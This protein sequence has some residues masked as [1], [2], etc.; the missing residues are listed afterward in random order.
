[1]VRVRPFFLLRMRVVFVDIPVS[2][3]HLISIIFW[4]LCLLGR[5]LLTVCLFRC[6]YW[7]NF[8]ATIPTTD[9]CC[10]LDYS[11]GQAQL[12]AVVLGKNIL[13]PKPSH[14][15]CG[16][17]CNIYIVGADSDSASQ[18]CPEKIREELGAILHVVG[19]MPRWP[20]ITYV[21]I[22]FHDIFKLDI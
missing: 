18:P 15:I 3:I 1:M 12:Y 21:P 9:C 19:F 20:H 13:F 10:V 7:V 14:C 11:R 16:C 5:G 17:G 8:I 2:A 6:I 4:F 22:G